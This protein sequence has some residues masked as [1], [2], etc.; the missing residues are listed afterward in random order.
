MA[1]TNPNLGLQQGDATRLR[2]AIAILQQVRTVWANDARYSS[3]VPEI[4]RVSVSLDA[5]TTMIEGYLAVQGT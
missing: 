2:N 3:Q 4:D 5:L 1:I